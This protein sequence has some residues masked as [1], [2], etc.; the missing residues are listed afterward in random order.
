[1]YTLD[2][3]ITIGKFHFTGVNEVR[4]ERSIHSFE[5]R[6]IIKLPAKAWVKKKGKSEPTK[7]TTAALFAEGDAVTVKL[8]YD[9]KLQTEFEGF[10]KR[11][12]MGM[13]IE[14]ECEGY[15]RLLRL[16]TLTANLSKGIDVKKLLQTLCEGTGIK[17][18][19]P[20]TF[21]MYG[22]NFTGAD[23]LAVLD[24]IKKVSDGQ[25][26][27]FF[28]EPKKL[29]CGLVYTP[30]LAGT[31]VYDLPT[32]R[33]R[34][35][36]NC[37]KDGALRE[38]VPS[39]KVQIIINGQLASGD[40]VRTES[41]DKVATRKLR[42][43]I[44]GVKDVA[45]IKTFANEKANNM[46][47]AGYEGYVTGFLQPYCQ[48]GWSAV[49]KDDDYPERDGTYLVESTTVTFGQNGARRMVEMGPKLSGGK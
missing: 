22:R 6:C 21:T 23:G 32:V 12:N 40:A 43:L 9:G 45:V 24:E 31:K 30:F 14:I 49:V 28:I 15:S 38:R 11:R 5:D 34:L 41:D 20:A 2:S 47:Y 35:G 42:T 4:I 1:M 37:I 29:W 16:K 33:Y 44:N 13:P 26:T 18:E 7:T 36:Y 8:G 39:E 17:V 48:P 10:V 25:M 3:D 19:V 46:N 27:I